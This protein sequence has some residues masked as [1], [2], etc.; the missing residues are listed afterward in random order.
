MET[1]QIKI[2]R[3]DVQRSTF[4]TDDSAP[5]PASMPLLYQLIKGPVCF[6]GIITVPGTAAL[7]VRR[8][9]H[10]MMPWDKT[11]HCD[12]YRGINERP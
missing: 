5:T 7:I 9:M 3:A 12:E 10:S 8:H 1:K 4:R 11:S 6:L 2:V